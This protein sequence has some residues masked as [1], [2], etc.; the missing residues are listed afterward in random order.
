MKM[1]RLS[2]NWKKIIRKA[3]SF[4]LIALAGVMSGCELVLPMFSGAMPRGLFA[5]L[6]FLF[7]AAALIARLVA[8]KDMADL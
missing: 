4:R 5:A 3:W 1:M 2:L 6:S 8:Q 7:A